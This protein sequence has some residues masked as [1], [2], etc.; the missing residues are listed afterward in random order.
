MRRAIPWVALL[1][2]LAGC[3]PGGGGGPGATK[4]SA[5][6]PE[7]VG[8]AYRAG[9]VP[10]RPDDPAWDAVPAK[11]IALVPH[12]D[13]VLA[14]LWF[15]AV[16]D[17]AAALVGRTWGHIRIGAKSL[18]GSAACFLACWAA[19]AVFLDSPGG[20]VP[21]AAVGA[22]T[23]ALLEALPMPLDDNLWI[24]VVSGLV[25]TLLRTL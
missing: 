2:L 3:G 21:E 7:A 11:T 25:L 14:S 5:K 1:A 9:G 8:V 22:F 16:G 13:V 19:G 4:E 15:L 6:E 23:A 20:G 10:V 17:A 12:R 18:E 24:P